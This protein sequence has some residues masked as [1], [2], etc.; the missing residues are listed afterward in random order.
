MNIKEL[1]KLCHE[2][3]VS[4][5]FWESQCKECHG[6]GKQGLNAHWELGKKRPVS[7]SV[8]KC[9]ECNGTGYI[10]L[11]RNKGELLAL[12]HSEISEALEALRKNDRQL[13]SE[14]W[15]KNT[16]EDEISD[17][18]IRICDLA[19]YENIDLEWQLEKKLEYNKH[20]KIKHGKL[21]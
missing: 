20:R 10:P 3:A 16:F 17:A 13:S 19:E 15:R 18:I 7:Y 1:Q 4:K 11:D 12:I 9:L 6:T 21:F 14:P 5:K 8:Y 2:I